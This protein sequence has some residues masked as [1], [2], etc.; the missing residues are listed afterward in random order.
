MEGQSATLDDV[1]LKGSTGMLVGFEI[2]EDGY[3]TPYVKS[4]EEESA[5]V[6]TTIGG[7]ATMQL[8]AN[9]PRPHAS[10]SVSINI[11]SGTASAQVS[12]TAPRLGKAK[13][14]NPRPGP[15]LMLPPW[16]SANL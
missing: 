3:G 11:T 15:M 10:A 14:S 8:S 13:K 2:I 12:A 7:S 5:K 16:E 9:A 1:V 6:T 4:S